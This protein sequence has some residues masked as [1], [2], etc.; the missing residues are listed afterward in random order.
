MLIRQ[1][2]SEVQQVLMAE[3]CFVST[4]RNALRP[5]KM[6]WLLLHPF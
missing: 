2:K 1:F 5:Y 3:M 6:P 4:G